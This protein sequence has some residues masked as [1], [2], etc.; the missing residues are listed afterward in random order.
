MNGT[1]GISRWPRLVFVW[2]IRRYQSLSRFT[3][4]MC[5]FTPTCSE[6]TRIAIETHG[7]LKGMWLGLLRLL[8]CNPFCKG[9]Y[10]P[11]PGAPVPDSTSNKNT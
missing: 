5:R 2:L 11:V 7:V 3:P 4:P 8:R 10:D 6:Y 1:A 9:G